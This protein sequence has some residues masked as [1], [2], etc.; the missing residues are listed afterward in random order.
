MLR[1]QATTSTTKPLSGRLLLAGQ[2]V[3]LTGW[4]STVL[5]VTAANRSFELE[6]GVAYAAPFSYNEF[7]VDD[8]LYAVYPGTIE[9]RDYD[10]NSLG[11][12]TWTAEALAAAYGVQDEPYLVVN[13]EL[14]LPDDPLQQM[15]YIHLVPRADDIYE[16]IK[17]TAEDDGQEVAYRPDFDARKKYIQETD[18]L[19]IDPELATEE[20]LEDNI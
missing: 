6:L 13:S 8:I 16:N 19:N 20:R 2:L 18:P 11:M 7:M 17:Y 4:V 5:P 9:I 12:K 10:G 3:S 14:D 1:V 15:R